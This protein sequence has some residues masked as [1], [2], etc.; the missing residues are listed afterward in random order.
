M[1]LPQLFGISGFFRFM[2]CDK[3]AFERFVSLASFGSFL[4]SVIFPKRNDE[5]SRR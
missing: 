2:I 5:S 4:L 1:R 3:E